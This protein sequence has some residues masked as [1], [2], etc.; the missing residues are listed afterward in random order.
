LKM[1]PDSS[2]IQPE[3]V[4]EVQLRTGEESSSERFIPIQISV[5]LLAAAL[6]FG[7]FWLFLKFK[8]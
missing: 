7:L 4:S 8:L 2:V 3:Q 6:V 5:A 1:T